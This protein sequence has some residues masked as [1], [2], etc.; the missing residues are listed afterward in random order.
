MNWLDIAIIIVITILT[1]IGL[2]TGIIRAAATA[3]GIVVGAILASRFYL[4]L[5]GALSIVI[6]N[7]TWAKTVSF[8]LI[9]VLALAAIT[10]VGS[11]IRR[12]SSS[13]L[14]LGWL[15]GLVGGAL[16]F[17]VGA[18][19]LSVIMSVLG[20]FEGLGMSEA[21]KKSTVAPLI[22]TWMPVFLDLLPKEFDVR[23]L[24]TL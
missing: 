12:V 21:I 7:E 4:A 10:I 15:D 23:S 22:M 11:M 2:R 5:S 3:V 17:L 8:I 18:G 24:L 20:S 13:L 14:F 6:Q 19:I 9:Y 16:G 1:L